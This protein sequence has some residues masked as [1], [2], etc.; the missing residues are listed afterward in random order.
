[1]TRIRRLLVVIPA[2]LSLLTVAAPV[3]AHSNNPPTA[4]ALFVS[5]SQV[6]VGDSVTVRGAGF[7]VGTK[8]AVL[9]ACGGKVTALG[10]VDVGASTSVDATV[11]LATAC[12]WTITLKG[13]AAYTGASLALSAKVVA[14]LP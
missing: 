8:V 1:M 2:V 13:Q 11:K 4:G 9:L 7:A 10:S 6:Y 3:S 5:A 12:T 14:T